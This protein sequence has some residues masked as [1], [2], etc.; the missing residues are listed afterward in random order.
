[1]ELALTLREKL[2]LRKILGTKREE[3]TGNWRKLHNEELY[4]L[5][6]LPNFLGSQVKK[7]GMG[8]HVAYMREKRTTRFWLGN[9]FEDMEWYV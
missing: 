2:M 5:Y 6:S 8:R 7:D 1:V 9:N 4:D 3:L